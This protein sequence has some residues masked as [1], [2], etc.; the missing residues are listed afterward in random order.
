VTSPRSFLLASFVAATLLC[1][2]GRTAR[3]ESPFD[4]KWRQSALREDFTVQKWQT[5]CGPQPRSSSTGG[6]ETVSVRAE[7]DVLSFVGGGRVFKSNQ[8]YDPLP[9]LV[10]ETYSHAADSR[11]WRTRCATPPGDP[12]KTVMQ[13][14]VA[15][16]SDSHIEV[17]E[18]GR[19]EIAHEDGL[20]VADVRR[21]RSFD[22]IQK[23]TPAATAT[24]S[25]PPAPTPT[26]TQTTPPP[27]PKEEPKPTSTCASPG[28]A[29]RLEVRPSKKLLRAGETFTFRAKVV[30]R[31]GCPLADDV[32][33]AAS[34]EASSAHVTVD[35]KGLVTVPDGTPE[36]EYTLEATADG[37]SAKVTLS[38]ST[39]ANYDALLAKDGLNSAGETDTASVTSFPGAS[40]GSSEVAAEDGHTKRRAIFVGIIG[41]LVVA[42]GVA[43]VVLRKR[44]KKAQAL[45]AD[46]LQ[47]Y[48]DR[49]RET[50]ARNEAEE[51]EY[52][53]KKRAHDESV[54]AAD[55]AKAKLA[56]ARAARAAAARST[57]AVVEPPVERSCPTCK[58]TFQDTQFC[59]HDGTKLSDKAPEDLT[60]GLLCPTCK[61]AF[62]EGTKTCPDHGDELAPL[63]AQARAAP[64]KAAKGKICPSCGARFEG[65]ATFCGKDGT[66][67]VLLN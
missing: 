33:W 46:T 54:R 53:R 59:P 1:G 52:A 28:P 60:H 11:L 45:E 2:L 26:P 9:T 67:L 48:E 63:P 10:R 55:E 20:C 39:A 51:A 66:S 12:R 42:L 64:V 32:K 56:A 41:T 14:L 40:I 6:G 15:A 22:L 19:Y 18:T 13:T 3:A 5:G 49:V 62:P 25:A 17:T 21:S 23:D 65:A 57:G 37:K 31:E 35:A 29:A 61:R 43:Y 4:G 24:A 58:R 44:Q 7:G 27:P 16:T 50:S 36:G 8:C 38:I 30:D 34:K 47:R